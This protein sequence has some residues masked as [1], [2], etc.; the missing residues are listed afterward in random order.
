MGLMDNIRGLFSGSKNNA[1][2]QSQVNENY[3]KARLAERIVDLA[4]KIMRINSFES[5]VRNLANASSYDLQRKSLA[6]LQELN[7]RLEFKLSQ[8]TKQAPT[9][10]D[11]LEASKWTGQAPNGMS[12]HDFDRYQRSDD[13]AR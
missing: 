10:N 13:S 7:A 2:V 9:A 4:G 12:N 11:S 5:S 1:P 8:L 3:E 6:E